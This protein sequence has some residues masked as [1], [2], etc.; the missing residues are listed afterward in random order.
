MQS[1]KKVEFEVSTFRPSSGPEFEIRQ[2]GFRLN[3]RPVHQKRAGFLV[4]YSITNQQSF[5][6][7]RTMRDQIIIRVKI[8]AVVGPVDL[9]HIFVFQIDMDIQRQN[10]KIEHHHDSSALDNNHQTMSNIL[11]MDDGDMDNGQQQQKQRVVVNSL[12]MTRKLMMTET[13]HLVDRVSLIGKRL[14]GKLFFLGKLHF[15][16]F[17]VENLPCSNS[18]TTDKFEDVKAVA[19]EAGKKSK[20]QK[21]GRIILH[22]RSRRNNAK[23]G[24]KGRNRR[25]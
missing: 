21:M 14:L 17:F 15:A 23:G 4:V 7:I 25:K 18:T 10:V 2:N 8:C 22:E 9:H 6:D 3:A 16:F 20:C 19:K 5:H 11:D 13:I 24:G 1:C 12:N